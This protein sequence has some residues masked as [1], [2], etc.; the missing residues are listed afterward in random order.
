MDEEDLK[1]E[2]ENRVEYYKIRLILSIIVFSMIVVGVSFLGVFDYSFDTEHYK[3]SERIMGKE[4][5][6]TN[7]FI[8]GEFH[9]YVFTN[10]YCFDVDL[11]DYNQLD[12]NESVVLRSGGYGNFVQLCMD[13]KYYVSE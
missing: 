10:N 3:Y 4:I 8:S 9:Y 5:V 11:N 2:L 7:G 6:W 13:D 12:V 1:K